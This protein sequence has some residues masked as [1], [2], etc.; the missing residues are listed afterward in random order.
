VDTRK[1]ARC[2]EVERFEQLKSGFPET[3]QLSDTALPR[4]A[5]LPPVD[6]A[7]IPEG[8]LASGFEIDLGCGAGSFL[9]GQAARF[10]ERRF[11]GVERLLDRVRRSS[12]RVAG[13]PNAAVIRADT[14][15]LIH[16]LPDGCALAV[17]LLFPD[18][19]PKRKQKH[20]RMVQEPFLTQVHRI[21]RPSG[22]LELVTDHADYFRW[23]EREVTRHGCWR[24]LPWPEDSERPLTNFER[25]FREQG[26]SIHQMRLEP[27]AGDRERITCESPRIGCVP[28]VDENN[29]RSGSNQEIDASS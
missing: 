27:L 24:S 12:R 13:L 28:A 20:R 10:P 26:L 18:P 21:L 7:E 16:A 4:L 5:F 25:Q 11:L 23:M 6:L 15:Q 1:K 2:I 8:W 3:L 17:Y 19:W 29:P 22:F 9:A 14:Q